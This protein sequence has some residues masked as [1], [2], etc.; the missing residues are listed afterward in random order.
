[1][2]LTF[3]LGI[4]LLLWVLYDLFTG[5]VWLHREFKRKQEPL[6]YWSILILWLAVA[7]SCFYWEL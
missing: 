4:F 1:M 2:S 3:T 6:S 5:Q 7:L